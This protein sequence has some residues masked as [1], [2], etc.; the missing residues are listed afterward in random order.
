[1]SSFNEGVNLFS[2]TVEYAL[3]A[4]VFLASEAPEASTTNQIAEATRIPPAYLSKVL[5]ALGRGGVVRSQ[6]GVGGG[7]SLHKTPEE[8]TLLEV[9][10]AVDPI[11]R[12]RTCPL[13]LSAHGA[14]LCPLH[15]RLDSALE[16]VEKAF[17]ETTLADILMEPSTSIPLCDFPSVSDQ[18][19]K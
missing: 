4:V 17:A 1:M 18:E 15:K 3:R 10:N 19:A 13:E 7:M 5:Q 9:V 6:R 16:S 11:I 2:Q 14:K 8:L 12:I